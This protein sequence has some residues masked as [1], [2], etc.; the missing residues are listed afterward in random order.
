[1]P[2]RKNGTIDVV[3]AR[4]ILT[5]VP[6]WLPKLVTTFGVV[7]V[8]AGVSWDFVDVGTYFRPDF[9]TDYAELFLIMLG[10]GILLSAGGTIAWARQWDRRERLR[11]AGAIFVLVVIAFFIVPNNV[12]GPGM[13]LGF[14]A[15][16]ACILSLVLGVV[17]VVTGDHPANPK[18]VE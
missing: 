3:S 10:V 18:S 15:I 16:C 17:A 5:F 12:H 7:C 2:G 8:I 6:S 4:Y 14:A 13:L 11:V 9:F 1:M